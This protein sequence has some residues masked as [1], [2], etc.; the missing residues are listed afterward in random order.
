M[1]RKDGDK[2]ALG[3]M[4]LAQQIDVYLICKN[5]NFVT[6]LTILRKI[7]RIL[8]KILLCILFVL[9]FNLGV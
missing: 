9:K 3:L 8:C 2:D 4:H 1:W 5:S 6:L 7:Y